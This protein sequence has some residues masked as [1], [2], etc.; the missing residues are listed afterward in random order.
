[1]K[2]LAAIL[3]AIMLFGP[4]DGKKSGRTG[5]AHYAAER[6][7]NAESAYREGIVAARDAGVDRVHA[8]LLN[9]LGA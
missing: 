2:H 9:N 4:G 7:E 5:N 8:G 6:Y 3:I 1:M